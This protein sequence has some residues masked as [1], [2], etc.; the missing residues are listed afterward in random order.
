MSP[1]A[2]DHATSVE[3]AY[4]ALRDAMTDGDTATLDDLLD[5]EFTLTHMTGL[6]QPR[7]EWLQEI[8]SGSMTYHTISDVDITAREDTLG[9][10]QLTVRTLTD[11]TI[12]GTRHTWRLVLEVHFAPLREG[13]L[14]T[15]VVAS[16]W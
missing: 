9:L 14:I 11:A 12:W 5:R 2:D 3:A 8:D 13:W 4:A 1:R 7:R 16:T 15:N 10:P 6:V